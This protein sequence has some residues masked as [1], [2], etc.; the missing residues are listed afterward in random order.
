M[1]DGEEVDSSQRKCNYCK[2]RVIEALECLRCNANYHRSCANR[3]EKGNF[4][5]NLIC[6][7]D[8]AEKREVKLLK[9]NKPLNR[10]EKGDLVSEMDET[11]L[12]N[13]IQAYFKQYLKPVER[14]LGDLE[15]SIQFMSD[16]FEAQKTRFEELLEETRA[17]RRENETLK[18]HV[19]NLQIKFDEL[20]VKERECNIIID[21]V[22]KQNE[23]KTMKTVTN[24]MAAMNLKIQNNEI[25]ESFRLGKRD[26]GPILV[27]LKS[28]ETKHNIISTIRKLKGT[29][30]AKCRLEGENRKIYIN[31]DLPKG[32][33]SLFKKVRDI[34]MEKGYAAAFC[35]NGTIYLKRKENDAPMKIRSEKDVF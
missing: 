8:H 4:S 24:I 21:G 26:G 25:L 27:K 34:K 16:S 17:L 35:N 20:E 18:E 11:R 32:K 5:G 33:R 29:T 31:E 3:V 28:R 30:V 2:K 7:E 10:A 6:C 19:N 22:P 15:K 23:S 13:I 9:I 1:A 12:R 14:K